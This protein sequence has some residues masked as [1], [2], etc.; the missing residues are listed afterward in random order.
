[1]NRRTMLGGVAGVAGGTLMVGATA[2]AKPKKKGPGVITLP[3]TGKRTSTGPTGLPLVQRL[4]GT[5]SISGFA[6][7]DGALMAV[8]T[9]VAR[10]TDVLTG[11][12][13][14][15]VSEDVAVPVNLAASTLTCDVLSLVL[16][17][18]HLELLGLVIDLNQV[19]L[20][21]TADPL[22]GLLGQLLCALA[23]LPLLDVIADILN[24]I[25]DLFGAL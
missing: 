22:G 5:L 14:G 15:S 12:R 7:E 20:N 11:A 4:A 19:V 21:I 3:V 2:L 17:P 10:A 13:L 16:G 23:G 24:R 18:L 1:M 8:G 6:V 25:L 9:L